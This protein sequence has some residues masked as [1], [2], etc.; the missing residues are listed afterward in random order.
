MSGI[1]EEISI[2]W[3]CGSGIASTSTPPKRS[4]TA[5]PK[6]S[7]PFSFASKRAEY[8]ANRVN[9]MAQLV[10][11]PCIA[12]SVDEMITGSNESDPN[13]S[14]GNGNVRVTSQISRHVSEKIALFSFL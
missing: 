7:T 10:M 8:M 1:E 3:T 6:S 9:T 13:K 5:Q 12:P 2:G 4:P 11:A 14:L